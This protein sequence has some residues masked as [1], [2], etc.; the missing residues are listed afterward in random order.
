M[1]RDVSKKIAVSAVVAAAFL[2]P[3]AANA[4]T[5]SPGSFFLNSWHPVQ[6]AEVCDGPGTVGNV[7]YGDARSVALL[8][9]GFQ[10]SP[11]YPFYN[12]TIT[13]TEWLQWSADNGA[14]WTN[15]QS[16]TASLTVAPGH[17]FTMGDTQFNMGQYGGLFYRVRVAAEWKVGTATIATD[18]ISY[19]PSWM[20]ASGASRLG[21]QGNEGVCWIP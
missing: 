7:T 17:A 18:L 1:F 20:T 10:R 4:S 13:A 2:I 11:L 9:I 15:W 21:A 5:G 16:R 14:S 3:V 6:Y 8:S 12:Q 19:S